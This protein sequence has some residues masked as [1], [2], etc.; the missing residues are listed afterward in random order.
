MNPAEQ[1]LQV[2]TGYM[3]SSALY[4]AL[5]LDIPDHLAGGPT[6]AADLAKACGAKEDPLYRVLRL[7]S[8]LG[9]FDETSPGTFALNAAGGLLRK[10][11]PGSLRSMAVF[12][13]DPF[14]YRVYANI[15]DSMKT[16]TPA[17]ETT[18]GMPMFKYLES[19]PAYSKTFNDA[20]TA[21][22]APVAGAAL[23]AYDFS[24]I[25]TLVDVAGGHGEVLKSILTANPAMRGI[26]CDLSHVVEGAKPRIAGA[27]LSDRM[28]AV[29]CDFFQ[30]VPEGGDAYIMKH[31]IHDWYDDKASLILRNIAKAMGAKK[32]KVIL[33]EAVIAPGGAPD[34]GKF[35]DIE[36]LL[37]P[38]GRERTEEEFR[39]LF[40]GAGFALTKIVPT[41]S[42]ASVIEAVRW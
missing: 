9:I 18:L 32:G 8:T 40:A 21:L 17:S 5:A 38:G 36:M 34:F 22:S 12:L 27:G 4:A 26:V 25:G 14:H 13:P 3:A 23:E 11:A 6:T 28:Q 10:D 7:L 16:G 24:G 35:I 19:D 15:M 20:M 39:A 2:A 1:I 29:P 37:F 42:P 41:K 30:S 31:I 33:L